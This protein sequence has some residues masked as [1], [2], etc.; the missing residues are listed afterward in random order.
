[1]LL[2]DFSYPQYSLWNVA[3]GYPLDTT[4]NAQITLLST[5]YGTWRMNG[6]DSITIE[7]ADGYEG[8]HVSLALGPDTLRG[9]ALKYSDVGPA[10]NPT[11]PMFAVPADC[12]AGT[13]RKQ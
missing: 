12:P 2:T 3:I 7:W 10:V 13:Q 6:P 8:I 1:M 11:A 4:G 5:A 9:T